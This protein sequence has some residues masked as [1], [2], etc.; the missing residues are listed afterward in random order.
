MLYFLWKNMC[1]KNR[2]WWTSGLRLH[3]ISQL[4]VATEGP[5]LESQLGIRITID[6]SELGIA[7]RYSNSRVPGDM[8]GLQYKT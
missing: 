5:G 3:A 1:I 4:I 8:C 7:C 6:C 2:P